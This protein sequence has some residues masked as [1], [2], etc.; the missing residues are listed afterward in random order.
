MSEMG[1][2]G[3]QGWTPRQRA[4]NRGHSQELK[5][6]EDYQKSRLF[7]APPQPIQSEQVVISGEFA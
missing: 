4:E 1:Q 6:L 2:L 5:L 7:I 3:T